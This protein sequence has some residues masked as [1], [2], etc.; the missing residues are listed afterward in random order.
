MSSLVASLARVLCVLRPSFS[1]ASQ[2]KMRGLLLS[3][4]WQRVVDGYAHRQRDPSVGRFVRLESRRSSV[5]G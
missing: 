5:P 2:R 3:S 1:L 4:S